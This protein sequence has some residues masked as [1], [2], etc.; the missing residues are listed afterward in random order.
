MWTAIDLGES[1]IWIGASSRFSSSAEW[2]WP[3]T[4]LTLRI[5]INGRFLVAKRTGVQRAAYNL[6]KTLF[7][8][9]VIEKTYLH[10]MLQFPCLTSESPQ[11]EN[12]H[13][14]RRVTLYVW[15]FRSVNWTHEKSAP[16]PSLLLHNPPH[17]NS[18]WLRYR[19]LTHQCTTFR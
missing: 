15:T 4:R 8:V 5:G 3:G 19:T 7:E 12:N 13:V 11:F 10:S 14:N 17:L 2:S 16:L 6:I 9:L 18:Q 1:C